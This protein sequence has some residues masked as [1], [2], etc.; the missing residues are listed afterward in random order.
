MVYAP[1]QSPGGADRIDPFAQERIMDG[2][3]TEIMTLPTGGEDIKKCSW[4]GIPLQSAVQDKPGFA[5]EGLGP[6]PGYLPALF[7]D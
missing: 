1:G 3:G 2:G 6:R 4:R 5:G 7:P